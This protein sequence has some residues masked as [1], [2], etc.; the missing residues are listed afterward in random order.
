MKRITVSEKVCILRRGVSP[1]YF[2]FLSRVKRQEMEVFSYNR[3]KA[4]FETRIECILSF[5]FSFSVGFLGHVH[6]QYPKVPLT[7][8]VFTRVQVIES[9]LDHLKVMCATSFSWL[10]QVYLKVHG[11]YTISSNARILQCCELHI[12]TF[13]T[14][15]LKSIILSK[16]EFCH[17]L[18]L[19]FFLYR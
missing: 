13:C 11:R 10:E 4:G 14:F 15:T 19:S 2:I 17:K 8:D 5:F 12:S 7:P 6:R 3:G 18:I 1:T 9:Y 16:G